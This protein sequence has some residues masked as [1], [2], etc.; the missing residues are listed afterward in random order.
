MPAEVEFGAQPV[1]KVGG[2]PLPSELALVLVETTMNDHLHLPH[3]LELRFRDDGHD[4]LSRGGLTVGKEIEL[5]ASEVGSSSAVHPLFKGEVTSLESHYDASSGTHTVVRAYDRSHR[6]M[7][8]RTTRAWE[9]TDLADLAR[10]LAG[11][12]GLSIGSLMT[13]G[14]RYP[15]VAQLNETNWDFLHRLAREANHEVVM[16]LGELQLRPP[17]P[18]DDA[19]RGADVRQE[20]APLQ[21]VLGTNL[22]SLRVRVT[23]ASQV[24]KTKVRAWDWT[25]KE[26]L[27]GRAPAE[28]KT[29]QI[30]QTPDQLA[31]VFSASDALLCDRPFD[32]LD[33]VNA[34]AKA[35][36]EL[37]AASCAEV[38]GTTDGNARLR[39]GSSVSISNTGQQFDGKFVVTSS[40]HV[41]SDEGYRTHFDITGR[42]E[43]SVLGLTGDGR[44]E[45]S[46]RIEGVVVGIVTNTR[47]PEDHGRVRVKF[48]WLSDDLESGW[49]RIATL[50]AG[51]DGRGTFAIPEVGDEVLVAFEHGDARRPYVIGQLWNGA[52]KAPVEPDDIDSGAG[53]INR[54][55]WRSRLGHRLRFGDAPDRS[56]IELRTADGKRSVHLDETGKKI[57]VTVDRTT[58]E[59]TD[60]GD[61][62]VDAAGNVQVK[63]KGNMTFEA[64]GTVEIKGAEVKVNG[65][66]RTE[67]KGGMITLN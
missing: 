35:L 57:L 65:S 32:T 18:A 64:T 61:V 28:T 22:R 4:A 41:F 63:A 8:H 55:E 36:A 31:Q 47:D 50:D 13:S 17:K 60:A 5:S 24:P 59:I 2:R 12:V 15:Y 56:D 66:A 30:D 1:V 43:R 7:K 33:E 44:R 9:E 25:K 40:R 23:A 37:I 27:E 26:P 3:M 39:A 54:R 42:Q 49:A 53:S 10:T 52:D 62:T 46:D 48:P 6:L 21:L 16:E 14:T 20:P 45:R 19:P 67:I 38:L 11:D 51:P 58:V 29:V 34:A